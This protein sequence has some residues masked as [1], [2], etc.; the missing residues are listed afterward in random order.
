[1]KIN[2][3]CLCHALCLQVSSIIGYILVAFAARYWQPRKYERLGIHSGK[4]SALL[5]LCLWKLKAL[6]SMPFAGQKPAM[7]LQGG[8]MA[9]PV[10]S[11]MHYN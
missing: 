11:C 6:G 5:S 9:L 3:V 10:P 4:S 2:L 8:I 1:M 7:E